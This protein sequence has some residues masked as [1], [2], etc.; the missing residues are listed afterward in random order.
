M[1]RSGGRTQRKRQELIQ[2][3]L[4]LFPRV[5]QCRVVHLVPELVRIV[6]EIVE[7]IEFNSQRRIPNVLPALRPERFPRRDP[8]VVVVLSEILGRKPVAPAFRLSGQEG[9]KRTTVDVGRNGHA[10]KFEQR[11][12]QVHVQDER[13]DSG[14]RG[15]ERRITQKEWNADR[16]LLSP[17]FDTQA[18]LPKEEPVVAREDDRRLV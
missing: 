7:L 16:F 15:R 10:A 17:A 8:R 13:F 3:A 6:P 4:E 2:S 14:P 12:R 18:V 11:R 9:E 1:N 5:G